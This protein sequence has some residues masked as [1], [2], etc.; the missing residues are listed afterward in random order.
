[1]LTGFALI[2]LKRVC[3]GA[4]LWLGGHSDLLG[5]VS[6]WKIGWWDNLSYCSFRLLG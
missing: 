2:L 4:E 3:L 5:V 6:I 1:M